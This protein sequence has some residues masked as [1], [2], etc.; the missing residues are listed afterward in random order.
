[1]TDRQRRLLERIER[2]TGKIAYIGAIEEENDDSE[3]DEDAVEAALTMTA[4]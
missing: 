3:A 1:M 4:S 2:A